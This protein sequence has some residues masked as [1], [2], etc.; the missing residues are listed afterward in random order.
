MMIKRI[1]KL[2]E[3]LKSLGFEVTHVFGNGTILPVSEAVLA[4]RDAWLAAGNDEFS[5]EENRLIEYE[6]IPLS[7]VIEALVEFAAEGRNEKLLALQDKRQAVKNL[8]P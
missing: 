6:K 8:F 2:T 3:H 5:V 1:E 4:A 7:Q